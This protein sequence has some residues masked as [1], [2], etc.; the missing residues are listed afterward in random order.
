MS[1]SADS[2][3]GTAPLSATPGSLTLNGGTL[4]TRINVTLDANRGISLGASGG[5]FD[6]ANNTM[7]TYGGIAAGPGACTKIDSGIL[8]LGGSNTYLGGTT[9]SAGI[10]QDG[11]ANALL[12]T[13][14]LT[15]NGTGTFDLNGFAQTVGGLADGGVNTGTVTDSGLAANFTV[16]DA[17]ANSF[18]GTIGG[19]LA[20]T[21]TGL[22]VLTLSH[23]NT[24][25]GATTIGAGTVQDGITN[26]LPISTTLTILGTSSTFDL[27]GF[28]QTVGGLVGTGTVTD[29]GSA[30]ALTVNDALANSFLGTIINGAN[31]L[32]LIKTG[33]GTLS[34]SHSNSYTGSTTIGGGTLSIFADANLGTVPPTATAGSL[35]LDG[36]TLAATAGFILNSNRGINLGVSGGTFDVASGN[37]LTYNGIVAGAGSLTDTD[38][39]TLVL[40]GNNAYTGT[41]TISGGGTLSISADSNLGTAP[42]ILAVPGSLTLN[43]G[44]L[45]T[46]ATF[47]LNSNRGI[48]LVGLGGIFD[49]ASG[50]ILTYSGIIAGGGSLTDSDDGTLV[51]GGTNTYFGTTT[52]SGGGT[53]GISADHNLGTAPVSATPD[54]LT[55]NGGTL[56]T[57]AIFTLSINRGISLGASGGTFDVASGTT[58]TYDGIAAGA[59]AIT[60]TD[61]GILI[62]GGSNT[63]LGGTTVSAGTLKDGTVNALP[64]TTILTV[65]RTATFDLNGSDQTVGGLADGGVNTGTVTDSGPAANFTIND[66]ADSSFSGTIEGALSLTNSG[67]GT[68]NLSQANT[69]TGITTIGAGIVQDGIAGALPAST[70]L[71]IQGTGT[72]DLGGFAQTVGGLMGTGT[73]TDSGAAATLTVNDALD[74]SFSGRSPMVPMPC[75]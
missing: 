2:N 56:A 47:T 71:S 60:K 32:S 74:N 66:A 5:T 19:A 59:G 72:F 40:G 62:L 67:A 20:L 6:V 73:V 9:V 48:S 38:T 11:T 41:T 30:A 64:T 45:A 4:A 44:T 13:A 69:Y 50:N 16:N 10:L 37:T 75:P 17:V 35:V 43:G 70:T 42:P 28:A 24:Y 29:S 46:T 21:K 63:Y 58:L 61:S 1:I 22:G 57:T 8:I 7:L 49:V 14:I 27:G 39:G 51:L 65:S 12:T 68:L 53:L 36:G 34:L 55:L 54:S 3:L 15:V 25:A 31:A 26:A 52:I 18:S 23:A 33:V